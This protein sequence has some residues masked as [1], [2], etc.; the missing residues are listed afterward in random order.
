MKRGPYKKRQ[1]RTASNASVP[2]TVSQQSTTTNEWEADTLQSYQ[3]QQQML[4]HGM[5]A[6]GT[7]PPLTQQESPLSSS[8][9]PDDAVLLGG[10]F[11]Y[12]QPC[13]DMSCLSSSSVSS[14]PLS[15]TFPPEQHVATAMS[16]WDE[17]FLPVEPTYQHV[18]QQPLTQPICYDAFTITSQQRKMTIPQEEPCYYSMPTATMEDQC[19]CVPPADMSSSLPWSSYQQ[20][21]SQPQPRGYWQSF[22]SAI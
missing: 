19:L 6:F 2:T 21:S 10:S 11:G 20:P 1:Q 9:L 3:Q 15:C 5:A 8:P 22:L 16:W 7:T 12:Q 18:K 17:G 13:T 4:D 14:S